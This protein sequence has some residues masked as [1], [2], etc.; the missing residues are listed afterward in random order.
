[1]WRGDAFS[2]VVSSLGNLFEALRTGTA[3]GAD[4]GGFGTFV[5]VIAD[6]ATPF[7]H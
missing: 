7:F 1:M 6:D 5:D 3:L 2:A 4:L